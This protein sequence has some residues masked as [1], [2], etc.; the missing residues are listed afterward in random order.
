MSWF[1]NLINDI[2]KLPE[3][4]NSFI[5]T[6]IQDTNKSISNVSHSIGSFV[7]DLP[8]N[9]TDHIDRTVDFAIKQT[10]KLVDL[11]AAGITK[12][13][14]GIGKGLAEI[15]KPLLQ[16]PILGGTALLGS[17]GILLASGAA[18]V[19]ALYIMKKF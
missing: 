15:G 4:T 6:A 10:S 16:N 14:S 13:S 5:A 17:G 19:G 12:I 2:K 1:G 18:L 7:K 9:F 3:K 11:E 8:S